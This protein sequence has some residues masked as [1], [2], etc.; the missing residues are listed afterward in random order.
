MLHTSSWLIEQLL[1]L[2]RLHYCNIALHVKVLL[3]IDDIMGCSLEGIISVRLKDLP[4]VAAMLSL[5]AALRHIH[6]RCASDR[7]IQIRLRIVHI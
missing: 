2:M 1:L 4:V 6:W 3:A 5:L 7:A